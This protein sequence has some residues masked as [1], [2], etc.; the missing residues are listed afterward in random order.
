MKITLKNKLI[1]AQ[2]TIK[3]Q[4][5]NLD[6]VARILYNRK[7]GDTFIYA[8]ITLASMIEEI[9]DKSWNGV[10]G[11]KDFDAESIVPFRERLIVI[12]NNDLGE[13]CL[14]EAFVHDGKWFWWKDKTEFLHKVK[15]W[16]KFPQVKTEISLYLNNNT[17]TS[18][19]TNNKLD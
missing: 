15:F 14:G 19:Q 10:F 18:S 9:K 3:S 12:Y 5:A 4:A 1:L 8:P 2:D 7:Y 11:E 13:E 16:S 6:A 17:N